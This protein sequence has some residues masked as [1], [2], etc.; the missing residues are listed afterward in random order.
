MR[1]AANSWSELGSAPSFGRG[2]EIAVVVFAVSAVASASVVSS[3]VDTAVNESDV[4]FVA[5]QGAAAQGLS[6]DGTNLTDREQVSA[7]PTPLTSM[8]ALAP[9]SPHTAPGEIAAI[10]SPAQAAP[11]DAVQNSDAGS[12]HM[13][14]KGDQLGRRSHGFYWSRIGERF[15]ERAARISGLSRGSISSER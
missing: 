13:L 8:P 6:G 14:R 12:R 3:L 4:P 11:M 1:F 9:V 2:W 5:T 7:A 15:S 10:S